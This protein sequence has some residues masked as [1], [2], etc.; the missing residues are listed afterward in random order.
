METKYTSPQLGRHDISETVGER[1]TAKMD[2][3]NPKQHPA[4]LRKYRGFSVCV[5]GVVG[6][7]KP[8]RRSDGPDTWKRLCQK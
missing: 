7:F 6:V 3:V 4:T 1:L 8:N 2:Q 5:G